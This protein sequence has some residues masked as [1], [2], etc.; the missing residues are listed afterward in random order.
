MIKRILLL[1]IIL[2]SNYF[3]VAFSPKPHQISG[4]GIVPLVP[5]FVITSTIATFMFAIDFAR[6]FFKLTYNYKTSYK[7]MILISSIIITM[8][9]FNRG[10]GK[11]FSL[12]YTLRRTYTQY[13]IPLPYRIWEF[14]IGG[15]FIVIFIASYISI[16]SV[17]MK[18]HIDKIPK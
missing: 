14:W 5:V 3:V 12:Y 11:F 13:I 10:I 9:L 1:F 7:F 2:L 17:Q 4:N 6:N 15:L 18:K 16:I 8:I